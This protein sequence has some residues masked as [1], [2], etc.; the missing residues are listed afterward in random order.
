MMQ[1]FQLLNT[2]SDT[3]KWLKWKSKNRELYTD[4]TA[5]SVWRTLRNN[6]K[7]F[8]SKSRY[9]SSVRVFL[10]TTNVRNPSRAMLPHWNNKEMIINYWLRFNNYSKTHQNVLILSFTKL[11]PNRIYIRLLFLQYFSFTVAVITGGFY[12][13]SISNYFK[14]INKSYFELLFRF[15]C[16]FRQHYF[17]GLLTLVLK[18]T[19]YWNFYAL[20]LQINLR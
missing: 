20:L 13:N 19:M 17:K 11:K 18:I 1:S 9:C 12:T 3:T 5:D 7:I 16:Y 2:K 10:D 6:Y 15:F 4:L 14:L 8:T